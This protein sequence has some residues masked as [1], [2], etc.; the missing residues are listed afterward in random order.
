MRCESV[1][2]RD[3]NAHGVWRAGGWLS[4]GEVLR[5]TSVL[6]RAINRQ[7]TQRVGGSALLIEEVARGLGHRVNGLRVAEGEKKYVHRCELLI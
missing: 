3:D 2:G 7:L 1:C 5:R 4:V 6:V